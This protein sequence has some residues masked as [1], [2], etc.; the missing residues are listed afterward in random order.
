MK[1]YTLELTYNQLYVL[2]Y[3]LDQA[4]RATDFDK[5]ENVYYGNSDFV[6]K[7]EKKEFNDLKKIAKLL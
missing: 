4:I 5:T 1:K 6:I 2:G 3:V 7:L